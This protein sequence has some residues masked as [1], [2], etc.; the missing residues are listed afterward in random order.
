VKGRNIDGVKVE[1]R[2]IIQHFLMHAFEKFYIGIYSYM[3][4]EDVMEVFA[5]LLP[6]DFIDQFVFIWGREQC[7]M[8]LGQ[9]T[10]GNYY[11]LK[12]LSRVYFACRGLPYGKEDQTLLINDEPCKAL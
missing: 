2:T 8:T 12:D 6:Q 10:T 11:C 9:L 3:L 4:I 5:L 1:T 7:L